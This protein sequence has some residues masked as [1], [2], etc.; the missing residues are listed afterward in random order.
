MSEA[1]RSRRILNISGPYAV[2]KDTLVNELMAKYPEL[3]HRVSTVTNRP[4]SA[5]ADPTYRTVSIERMREYEESDDF[6]VTHQFGGEVLYGTS[7]HEIR[8]QVAR[9]KICV[10]A[11]F[12]GPDGAGRM[13][14]VFGA[15]LFSIGLLAADG[16]ADQQ[17]SVLRARLTA[18]TRDD[19]EAVA[20]RLAYQIGPIE[21][22]LANLTVATE[23]GEMPVFDCVMVNDDLAS[24]IVEVSELFAKI[25]NI[26]KKAG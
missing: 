15:Q 23:D 18:R 16:G 4:S 22:V 1:N 19:E 20:T 17:L 7:I 10:H 14:E 9:N 24:T 12:A 8:E 5:S 6:I 21:Y 11:I 13:R 25:F 2:G 26:E 3:T